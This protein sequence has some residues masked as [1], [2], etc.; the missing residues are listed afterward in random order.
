M[1]FVFFFICLFVCTKLIVELSGATGLK[2]GMHVE[3]IVYRNKTKDMSN[4]STN[5]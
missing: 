3:H 4:I 5:F 2:F 1:T